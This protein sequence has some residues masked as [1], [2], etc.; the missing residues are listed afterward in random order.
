M[1]YTKDRIESFDD[2]FQCRLRIIDLP[3]AQKMCNP[4]VN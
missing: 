4:H 3:V 1:Q 2:C